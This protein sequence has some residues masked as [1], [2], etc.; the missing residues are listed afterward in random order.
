MTS[1]QNAASVPIIGGAQNP[2]Q[3]RVSAACLKAVSAF[4]FDEV[5][6]LD[7]QRELSDCRIFALC[8]RA[9]QRGLTAKNLMG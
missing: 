8:F 3:Y 4:V 1:V 9:R 6:M 2:N 7:G 5:P